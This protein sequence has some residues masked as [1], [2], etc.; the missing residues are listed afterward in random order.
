MT[1]E[2]RK[3]AIRAYQKE[4]NQKVLKAL[5][6]P[7]ILILFGLGYIY[8]IESVFDVQSKWAILPGII[9]MLVGL[10]SFKNISHRWGKI[11]EFDDDPVLDSKQDKLITFFSGLFIIVPFFSILIL[12]IWTQNFHDQWWFWLYS[13]I[14]GILFST[15]LY[16]ILKNK[17]AGFEQHNKQRLEELGRLWVLLL[18]IGILIFQGLLFSFTYFQNGEV[19]VTQQ[20]DLNEI[21]YKGNWVSARCSKAEFAMIKDKDSI[22]VEVVPVIFGIKY[23]KS[24]NAVK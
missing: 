6:W 17:V 11:P 2:E 8:L 14:F 7:V 4:N 20:N 22:Q 24:F 23:F 15:I 19:I 1:P 9:L 12:Q 21:K 13:I 18:L 16:N 5:K 10:V 3:A